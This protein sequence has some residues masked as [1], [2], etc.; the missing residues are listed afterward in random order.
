[1]ATGQ[2]R[3]P[4]K[5][6][7]R[8]EPI[9]ARY[10][11]FSPNMAQL[12]KMLKRDGIIPHDKA[13]FIDQGTMNSYSRREFIVGTKEGYIPTDKWFRAISEYDHA[14]IVKDHASK[15]LGKYV[16]MLQ[17]VRSLRSAS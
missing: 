13:V 9:L 14:D 10:K 12:N 8:D 4:E 1:M 2:Y 17:T 16:Q 5:L 15:N 6:P 7:V 11:M 3:K